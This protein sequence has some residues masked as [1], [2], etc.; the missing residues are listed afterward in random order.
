MKK[1]VLSLL[2]FAV[3]G[4]LLVSCKSGESALVSSTNLASK[5][6]RGYA[7]KDEF[8]S[9]SSK[10]Y[11]DE[12]GQVVKINDPED[13][14][15][16]KLQS[17]K[18][19]RSS[20]VLFYSKAK[21]KEFN[22]TLQLSV[23]PYPLKASTGTLTWVSDN[24]NVATVDQNGLVSAV[25]AGTANV[26]V[27]SEIGVQA[28]SR[29]VVNDNNILLSQL[30]KTTSKILATQNSEEFEPVETIYVLQDYVG[31][32]TCDGVVVSRS[33]YEQNFWISIP[34]SY[35]RIDSVDEDIKT[36]GGSVVPSHSAYT[37]Y[38]TRSYMSYIFCTSNN[39]ANYMKLDQSFL[40][41]EGKSQFDGLGE[42]LQSFF[43]SGSKIMTNQITDVLSQE[44]L[45]SGSDGYS[46]ALYR[47]TLGENSG[48]AAYTKTRTSAGRL[49]AEDAEYFDVPVG[50]YIKIEDEFRY[51]WENN[52]L[53]CKAINE[54]I[55]Y[56]IGSKNYVEEYDIN[57]YYQAR[58]VEILWPEVSSFTLVDSIFD[59]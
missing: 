26:T 33:K 56:S 6:A 28:K 52:T 1:K 51:L 25:S 29:I 59:L 42:I 17:L 13:P 2:Q 49:D 32:K 47:G 8:K 50:T 19:S 31:T 9:N 24:P 41:G 39:K 34:N 16:N 3:L 14:E 46:G 45:S 38:T 22:E 40:V 44:E 36:S 11:I 43:V 54:K 48:Q 18:I 37:F 10:V 55:S 15:V 53:S 4:T 23:T 12:D 35:F 20:A 27:T 58:G 30:G 5:I 21:G 7:L 57:Y